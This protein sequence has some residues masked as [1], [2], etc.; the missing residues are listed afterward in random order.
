[1]R[2]CH[3]A[4]PVD[5]SVL[6]RRGSRSGAEERPGARHSAAEAAGPEVAVVPK[7]A[8]GPDEAA[9]LRGR[10]AAVGCAVALDRMASPGFLDEAG[11]PGVVGPALVRRWGIGVSG[12]TGS[13]SRRRTS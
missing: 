11:I 10:G 8:A 6:G 13:A 12:G 1:M 5:A 7:E 2:S 9:V 4:G 3:G